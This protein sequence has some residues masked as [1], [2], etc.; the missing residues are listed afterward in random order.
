MYHT[1]QEF[2]QANYLKVDYLVSRF[3]EEYT[4]SN[5]VVNNSAKEITSMKGIAGW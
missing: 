5:A 2:W 3:I 1:E 4:C